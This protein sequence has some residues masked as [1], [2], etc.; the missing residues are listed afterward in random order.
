LNSPREQKT[1]ILEGSED[2]S[3]KIWLNGDLVHKAVSTRSGARIYDRFS[4]VTLKEGA[5]VLLVAIQNLNDRHYGLCSIG[6][7]AG[8]EYA[9]IPPGVGF[10]FSATETTT[11]LADDT[12]TLNLNAENITDLAGWQGDVT[13]DHGALEVVEITEGNFLKTDDATTFFQGGTLDNTAG[14]IT[15]LY[16]ARIS[17]SGV[18][19]SG[20]LLSVTFKAKAAGKTQV[21]LENFEF[22]SITGDIIPALPPNITIAVGEYPAGDVNQDGRV[23][24]VDLVL[25]AKDLGSNTPFNLRTD[26][27][28][29]GVINI[30]DLILVAQNFGTSVDS[31]TASPLLAIDNKELMPAMV[32][33]WIDQASAE[34]DGSIVF[35]QGIENLERLLA[36]LIP[37]KTALLANYPNPFNPETWIPYHLAK[38]ADVALTIY[39]TD[40]AV[41]RTLALGHQSAGMYQS[42]SRAAHWNGKN[43]LGES[44]ASGVYFYTLTAG[45]FSATRK[46]LI[47][48]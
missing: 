28:R 6:F 36:S 16:S 43:A 26:V 7:D 20:T 14:K 18:S 3:V 41:V 17:E 23:S 11:L 31:A 25:V 15:N 32:Q 2:V 29:D 13:F 4:P 5:N 22:S 21:T 30:Q 38:P 10:T 27:N 34:N 9:V 24:I 33:A 48:K 47:M 39:A 8:T 42:R 45:E 1:K 37:E 44:V 12:F 35:Q 46:M 40:G 19:G